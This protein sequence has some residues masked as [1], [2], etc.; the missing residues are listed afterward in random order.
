MLFVFVP[1]VG[2][3]ISVFVP[4]PTMID[5]CIGMYV[6]FGMKPPWPRVTWLFAFIAVLSR[7]RVVYLTA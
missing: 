5:G 7:N 3:T 2:M 1:I 4:V 6:T